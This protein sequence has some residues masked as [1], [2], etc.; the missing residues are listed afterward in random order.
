M[1]CVAFLE[2]DLNWLQ[3]TRRLVFSP[4]RA[5]RGP[6][7]DRSEDKLR[8]RLPLPSVSLR[9]TFGSG[10][11][12]RGPLPALNSSELLETLGL[13][14]LTHYHVDA[15]LR[16]Q[17]APS[18]AAGYPCPPFQFATPLNSA[19]MQ[20]R[21]LATASLRRTGTDDWI[22][23]ADD[24]AHVDPTSRAAFCANRSV[25]LSFAPLHSCTPCYQAS[26][27][28]S[29]LERAIESATRAS[30]TAPLRSETEGRSIQL[31]G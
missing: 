25:H 13:T 15:C 2:V 24:I 31:L 1:C 27:S 6:C 9:H 12:Q 7:F 20:V 5:V 29:L 17:T 16:R 30:C 3:L 11:R 18:R 10:C 28:V 19:A 4:R 26:Y 8:S 23:A 21:W 22:N 14:P